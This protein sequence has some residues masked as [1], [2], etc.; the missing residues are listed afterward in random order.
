VR[1]ENNFFF[2]QISKLKAFI[3]VNLSSMNSNIGNNNSLVNNNQFRMEPIN[4][5]PVTTPFKGKGTVLG[6]IYF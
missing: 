5:Q 3:P 6:R 1:C 2:R 4:H